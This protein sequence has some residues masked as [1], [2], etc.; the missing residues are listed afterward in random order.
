MVDLIH[1][2]NI[3]LL[4]I[5]KIGKPLSWLSG[6][7]TTCGEVLQEGDAPVRIICI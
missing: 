1:Q 2:Q 4:W 6:I 5:V 7:P 3:Y